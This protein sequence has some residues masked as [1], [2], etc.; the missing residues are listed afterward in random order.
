MPTLDGIPNAEFRQ[1]R[2]PSDCQRYFLCINNKPRL[3][4]CGEGNAFNEDI[5]ACDGIE[6]VTACAQQ[7]QQQLKG[8][9]LNL[10][11][12]QQQQQKGSNNRQKF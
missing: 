3:Y 10:N 7:Y 12:N 1:Y 2:S 9:Q 5:N 8:Q 11:T 4:N 6:N